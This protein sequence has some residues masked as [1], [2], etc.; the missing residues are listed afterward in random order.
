[1]KRLGSAFLCGVI[2]AFWFLVMFYYQYHGPSY[3]VAFYYDHFYL[4]HLATYF[5]LGLIALRVWRF[6]RGQRVRIEFGLLDA[7][8]FALGVVALSTA[9]FVW[10]IVWPGLDEAKFVPYEIMPAFYVVALICFY[11]VVAINWRSNNALE[12]ERGR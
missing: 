9:Y 5:A 4:L 10:R 7:S 3:T 11:G 8:V 1:M 6:I 12:R 2:S